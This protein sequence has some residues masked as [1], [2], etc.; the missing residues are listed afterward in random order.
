VPEAFHL[1]PPEAGGFSE[2]H[3]LTTASPR[4][5][6]GIAEVRAW[7][8]AR[9]ATH[10][11]DLAAIRAAAADPAKLPPLRDCTPPAGWPRP[12]APIALDAYMRLGD[13]S[14]RSVL[15][16]AGCLNAQCTRLYN[17]LVEHRIVYAEIRCS[18]NNYADATCGRSAR[19]VLDDIRAA[20]QSAMDAARP[21]PGSRATLPRQPHRHRHSQGR[22]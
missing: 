21:V 8:A 4:I 2:V 7:F 1:L 11:D 6:D 15:R 20:F 13:N 17:H 19:A 22:R 18:P 3:V 10:G 5:D 12:P 14:G 16:D 9:F